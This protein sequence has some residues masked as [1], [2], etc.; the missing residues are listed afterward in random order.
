MFALAENCF[1][2]GK[3]VYKGLIW[4][5]REVYLRYEGFLAK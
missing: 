3:L 4:A 2:Q 5:V 1:S